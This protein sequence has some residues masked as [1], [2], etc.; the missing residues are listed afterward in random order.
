MSHAHQVII[1]YLISLFT[2]LWRGTQGSRKDPN[3]T[4]EFLNFLVEAAT[5]HSCKHALLTWAVAI[6]R[7]LVHLQALCRASILIGTYQSSSTKAAWPLLWWR[8][9]ILQQILVI[10]NSQT[11]GVQLSH[12]W[13]R[14]QLR[15]CQ[16]ATL[17]SSW[18]GMRMEL[19]LP[20]PPMG[21]P[22]AVWSLR[23][24]VSLSRCPLASQAHFLGPRLLAV[25]HRRATK[26]NPIRL[27]CL[28]TTP[29]GV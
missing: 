21:T 27:P 10:C 22:P 18:R 17:Q 9:L 12:S 4:N 24:G 1:T 13:L 3:S 16:W 6:M 15:P 14:L 11:L 5:K 20:M 19:M 23:P 7:G 2:R 25:R 28:H 8:M 26:P 29:Q